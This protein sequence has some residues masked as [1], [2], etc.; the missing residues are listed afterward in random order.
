MT[1]D[2]IA[3]L[4][5]A[6]FATLGAWRGGLASGAGVVTLAVSYLAAAIGARQ[7]GG[8]AASSLGG[9]AL[10]GPVVAGSLAF[11]VTFVLCGV[12]TAVLERWDRGRRGDEPRGACDR[13]V[14]GLFGVVRGALVVLLVSILATWLDAARDMGVL[15]GFDA[16]P[17]A[18]RSVVG[19]ATSR[20]IEGAVSA[21]LGGAD[22]SPGA[23]VAARMVARP[24]AALESFRSVLEDPRIRA[25][26]RDRLFWVLVENGAGERAIHQASFY[27]IVHDDEMRSWLADLGLVSAEAAADPAVV[28]A[29]MAAT[30]MRDFFASTS[31][32]SV[33]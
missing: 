19:E 29:P 28:R 2:L 30:L 26:Q 21:S 15:P 20:V 22:G 13:T 10:L 12:V 32:G 17:D 9:A 3:V 4:I 27:E 31:S 33:R 6:L 25:V 18:E 14:G 5:L 23:R 8:A 16:V 11:A 1:L 24:R 7:L